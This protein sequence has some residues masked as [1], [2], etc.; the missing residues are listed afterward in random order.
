MRLRVFIP[1]LIYFTV[2]WVSQRIKVAKFAYVSEELPAPFFRIKV[3]HD[4]WHSVLFLNNT[5]PL[6]L[7]FL[8]FYSEE[9]GKVQSK[10]R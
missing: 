3:P 8:R 2:F 6:A 9:E 7:H 10:C 4:S 5:F 1:V